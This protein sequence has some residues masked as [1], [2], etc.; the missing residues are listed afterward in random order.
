MSVTLAEM[1]SQ[2]LQQT[3]RSQRWLAR[4]MGVSP[5]TIT[6][7]LRGGKPDV[8]TLEKLARLLDRPLSV[9]LQVVG[10][11]APTADPSEE[12]LLKL[13]GD[14]WETLELVNILRRLHKPERE[15]VL[16]LVKVHLGEK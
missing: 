2:H 12:E 10:L 3:G 6:N 8:Q 13:L 14:D 15:R 7:I 16:H 5:M 9:L 4:E 11:L 1:V